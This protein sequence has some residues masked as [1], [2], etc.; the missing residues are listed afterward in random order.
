MHGL[1][2]FELRVRARALLLLGCASL[3]AISLGYVAYWRSIAASVEAGLYDFA[4]AERARGRTAQFEVQ[5][6]GG[7]PFWITV[8]LADA[9]L[10]DSPQAFGWLVATPALS[11]RARPWSL[12]NVAAS[13]PGGQV[14]RVEWQGGAVV[15]EATGATGAA[16]IRPGGRLRALSLAAPAAVFGPGADF[17]AEEIRLSAR[18]DP[19]GDALDATLT[20]ARVIP[21]PTLAPPFAAPITA[22]ALTARVAAPAALAG[23]VGALAAWR[24][25]GGRLDVPSFA[26]E[27]G[28]LRLEAAGTIRLDALLRPEGL[29]ELRGQGYQGVLDGLVAGGRLAERPAN[30]I[31]ALLDALA[32][33]RADGERTLALPLEAKGGSLFLG[34]LPILTLPPL[35]PGG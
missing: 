11:A 30:L 33:R 1:R 27:W 22:A 18:H 10:A 29:L 9:F 35:A 15:I 24:A 7:F 20:L 31:R 26:A 21:P 16:E 34:P 13:V 25:A 14:L 12:G 8:E 23:G 5:G 19:A 32:E 28:K 4:T 17:Q 6:I 2:L 3:A